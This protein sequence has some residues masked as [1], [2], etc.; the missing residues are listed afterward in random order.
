MIPGAKAELNL[1]GG[2]LAWLSAF[3]E[4]Q[5]LILRAVGVPARG[6]HVGASSQALPERMKRGL[7]EARSAEFRSAALATL[8]AEVGPAGG[9][10]D[11]LSLQ[12]KSAKWI[13]A[14]AGMTEGQGEDVHPRE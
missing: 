8:G 9:D 14:F 12:S 6:P 1:Q 4:A 10:A 3:L 5:S 7:F 13:P 11:C 2:V